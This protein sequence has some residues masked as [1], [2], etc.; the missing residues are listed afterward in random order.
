VVVGL[1]PDPDP[2]IVL[3]HLRSLVSLVR[4]SQFPVASCQQDW[5][6]ATGHWSLIR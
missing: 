3:S 2:I 5:E 1:E 6:L 4:S